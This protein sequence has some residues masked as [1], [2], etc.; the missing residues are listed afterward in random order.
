MGES[1]GM[2]QE[3]SIEA[4]EWSTSTHMQST[5]RAEENSQRTSTGVDDTPRAPP[6]PPQPP[7]EAAN[8]Q[9]EPPSVELEGERIP[10]P[11]CDVRRTR[12]E[13]N[14]SGPSEDNEDA[15][16]WLKKLVNMS[17]RISEGS[18]Q[19]GQEDSSKGAQDERDDLGDNAD[20][21]T[22]SWS[23]EDVGK[24]SKKLHKVLKHVRKQ[25]E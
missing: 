25:S 13:A 2:Q 10:N 21:S 14:M 5:T 18:K 17:D 20:A 15:R 11:S 4:K 19:R 1:A 7:D 8:Q 9:N 12:A 3:V 6:E 23:I 22:V 24:W 16:D